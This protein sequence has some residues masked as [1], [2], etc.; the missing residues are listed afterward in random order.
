MASL[1]RLG[2]SQ[3][4]NALHTNLTKNQG[5]QIHRGLVNEKG[6]TIGAGGAMSFSA[7]RIRKL[8]KRQN[9]TSFLEFWGVG[10]EEDFA[11]IHVNLFF[12]EN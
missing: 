4:Q 11:F 6:E 10:L 2:R 9:P 8:F 1:N 12:S 5:Y 3:G 7:D